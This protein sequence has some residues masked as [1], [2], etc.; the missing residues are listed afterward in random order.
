MKR[1]NATNTKAQWARFSLNVSDW[2]AYKISIDPTT[3]EIRRPFD[4]L[5]SYKFANDEKTKICHANTISMPGVVI[6]GKPWEISIENVKEDG[7]LHPFDESL[8]TIFQQDGSFFFTSPAGAAGANFGCEVGTYCTSEYRFTNTF[9]YVNGKLADISLWR[10]HDKRKPNKPFWSNDNKIKDGWQASFPDQ[11]ATG[12]ERTVKPNLEE[13]VSPNCSW[14]RE[15]WTSGGEEGNRFYFLPDNVTVSC[16]ADIGDDRNFHLAVCW[17][18]D[19]GRDRVIRE[20]TVH[21]SQS[22]FSSF[23]QGIYRQSKS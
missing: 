20:H 3:R 14:D 10:E 2:Y 18:D 8:R 21:Y 4:A 15:Y 1:A 13:D 5:R 22:R 23:K 11:K 9:L 19:S 6:N 17:V 7:L 12:E 16:P